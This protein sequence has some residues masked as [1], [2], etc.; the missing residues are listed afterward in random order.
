MARSIARGGARD[1]RDG[2]Q[3]AALTQH[4][5]RAV[6]VPESKVVDVRAQSF[7][8]CNPLIASRL[9][10]ACSGAVPNPAV[11]ATHPAGLSHAA[12]KGPVWPTPR[13]TSP[14]RQNRIRTCVSTRPT[15]HSGCRKDSCVDYLRRALHAA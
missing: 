5:Q 3:L 6:L 13:A 11:T 9:I 8:V 12:R 14:S 7:G 2:D 4:G 15:D 10:R 1:E